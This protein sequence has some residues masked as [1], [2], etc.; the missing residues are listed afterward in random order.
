MSWRLASRLSVLLSAILVIIVI[1]I[2]THGAQG[3]QAASLQGTD[4]GSVNAPD[5]RLNDQFGNAI[6]LSHFRGQPVVLTFLYTHCPDTCPLIADKL[7]LALG[8]LGSSSTRVGVLAVSTDPKNDTTQSA[9]QFSQTHHLLNQWHF[10]VGTQ[11]TLTPIWSAYSVYA[12]STTPTASDNNTVDHTVAIYL[13][14]KQGHERIYLGEDFDPNVLA[15]DLQTL[16][17][18]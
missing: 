8:K 7:H 5:F 16:L 12:A 15:S 6:S 11:A 4:L 10:L 18:Q 14:D 9:Y 2:I 3:S 13:I 1:F 17:K